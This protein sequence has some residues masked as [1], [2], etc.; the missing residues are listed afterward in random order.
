MGK[1]IKKKDKPHKKIK[2][3]CYFLSEEFDKWLHTQQ[4]LAPETMKEGDKLEDHLKPISFC[5]E[6][7]ICKEKM[8]DTTP[9]IFKFKKDLKIPKKPKRT[10]VPIQEQIQADYEEEME[11]DA[12]DEFYEDN[13][14]DG[15]DEKEEL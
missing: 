13:F 1:L 9:K 5:L 14:G 8:F 15:G 10:F 7:G 3:I 12:E 11:A 2:D 6:D 4:K